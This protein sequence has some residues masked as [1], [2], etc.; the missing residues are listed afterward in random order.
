MTPQTDHSA[1]RLDALMRLV[2]RYAAH[3]SAAAVLMAAVA[4]PYMIPENPDSAVFR[5]G[6]LGL[7]LLM[8]CALPVKEAFARAQKRPFIVSMAL[9]YLF[10]LALSLGSELF[11]YDGLLRGF[12]SFVRRMAVPVLAAPLLGGL[13]CRAALVR[14]DSLRRRLSLPLWA[15]ALAIFLCW[16]P[17][18]LAYYPGML[19]YDF[20]GEYSQHLADSYSNIHP[21][22]HSAV[23]NGIITLGELLHSR[24]FGVALYSVVQMVCFAL[25]L[26]YSCVF[27]QRRG[28]P[29]LV[30]FLMT[31]LYALH[32]IF[33]VM[34]LSMTKDTLFAAALLVLSLLTWELIESPEAF[35]RRRR[36][37]LLYIFCVVNTALMRNNG[38]FALAILL[39]GVIIAARG[40]RRRTALLCA[41]GVAA[42]LLTT[43]A[44][45]LI[46]TPETM[47]SFQ[48]YSLP[49][50]QLVRAYNSGAMSETEQAEIES[51][52]TDPAGLIVHPHLA[53]GAKGYL[54]RPRIQK[55]GGKFL[56]L[57]ARHAGTYAHEYLE[58]F[59]MLNVGSW[60]PDDL[61]HSTI[62]PDASWNDKGYLQTMECD[63]TEQGIETRCFLPKVKALYERICRRNEYQ[64]YPV[65]SVLFNTAAPFWVLML[66][67]ALLIAKRQT[68]YLPVVLGCMGLWLSYLFGPCTLPRYTLPLF[69][70]APAALW[71]A[72][73]PVCARFVQPSDV[74]DNLNR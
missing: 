43:G 54:D 57:W 47:P 16:L 38:L 67:G 68:R 71:L 45:N 3:L 46:Y 23:M 6:T 2:N 53:D 37:C 5:S 8:G 17:L 69:C 12:G 41:A 44:L 27:A 55:E 62:Y 4:A 50:Q 42:T 10:A 19:N 74:I 21:L 51:W 49:A 48:L 14:L 58:A 31:A 18:L 36:A 7:I 22:L 59:L 30:L 39:P 66:A 56:A 35:L 33:S 20:V 9:G 32:P 24:T 26:G 29:A 28:A 65:I 63:M 25:S 11:I 73:N 70:L 40:L 34:A 1:S 15:Y 72:L 13:C 64:K 61:S 60:Y 52:Y